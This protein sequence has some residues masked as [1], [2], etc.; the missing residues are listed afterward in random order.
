MERQVSVLIIARDEEINLPD[1]LNSVCG[2]AKDVFVVLDPAPRTARE[3]WR[4]RRGRYW[5]S[6]LLKVMPRKKIGRSKPPMDG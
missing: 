2:W 3:V 6:T 5:W 1:C 4:R